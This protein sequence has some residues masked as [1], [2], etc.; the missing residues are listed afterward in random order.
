MDRYLLS[1]CSIHDA[2]AENASFTLF[3]SFGSITILCHETPK[4]L[5]KPLIQ[6]AHLLSSAARDVDV[7][8]HKNVC[9]PGYFA[10][11]LLLLFRALQH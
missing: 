3:F 7:E 5:L 6:F 8:C 9:S 11:L 10:N 4:D 2:L 1:L